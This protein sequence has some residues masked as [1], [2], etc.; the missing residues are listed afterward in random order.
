MTNPLIPKTQQ[1][2][3]QD[4]IMPTQE[5]LQRRQQAFTK[6]RDE[7]FGKL[8]FCFKCNA[9]LGVRVRSGLQVE[10]VILHPRQSFS[11]RRCKQLYKSVNLV[12]GERATEVDM[13][14]ETKT[15]ELMSNGH[16]PSADEIHEQAIL[17]TRDLIE[18][19]GDG[20]RETTSTK[21]RKKK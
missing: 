5:E 7:M 8:Y 17:E 14:E 1:Q 6:Q 15:V 19:P 9:K 11:C 13:P 20:K 18:V 2:I 10:T 4:N 12:F 21:E 16:S 3:Q